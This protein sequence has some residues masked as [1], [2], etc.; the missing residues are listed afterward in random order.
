MPAGPSDETDK[1]TSGQLTEMIAKE[2]SSK[3]ESTASS[4][5]AHKNENNPQNQGKVGDKVQ[6]RD[7]TA[8]PGPAVL[9]AKE[10]NPKLEGTREDRNAK[11]AELN[12]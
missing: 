8:N 1:H 9:D 10:V 3:T 6:F 4:H 2:H 12:N 7:H 5:P 11:A